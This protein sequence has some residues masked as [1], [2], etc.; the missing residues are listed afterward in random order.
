M[1][2][3]DQWTM[4]NALA[5]AESAAA[6]TYCSPV[7]LQVINGRLQK[8]TTHKPRTDLVYKSCYQDPSC[9]WTDAE[10]CWP[11]FWT[12]WDCLWGVQSIRERNNGNAG[13]KSC[14]EKDPMNVAFKLAH[15]WQT[16][17][18]LHIGNYLYLRYSSIIINLYMNKTIWESPML[19]LPFCKLH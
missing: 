17:Q 5:T 1:K 15:Y 11:L 16:V 18:R 9:G 13:V 2:Q 8:Y 6:I 4:H 12:R 7:S 10:V 19:F 3:T 14:P